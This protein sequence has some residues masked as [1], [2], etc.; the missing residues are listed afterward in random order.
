MRE[1]VNLWVLSFLCFFSIQLLEGQEKQDF[2]FTKGADNMSVITMGSLRSPHCT[3]F[4]YPD[5]LVLHEIPKI[6]KQVKEHDSLNIVIKENPLIAF[7]DSIYLNKPIKYILNSHSHSHSLSTILPF[8]DRGAMLITAIENIEIYEKRGLFG[9]LTIADYSKSIIEISADTVLLSNTNNPIEVLYL[10]KSDYKSIPTPTYLF[11]NFPKQKLLATSCM[12]YLKDIDDRFGYKA[13][14]YSDR[15]INVNKIIADKN[16]KVESTLQ[17]YKFRSEH[18][19]RK[20]PVF[21]ASHLE[22]VLKYSWHRVQLSEHFQ[23]MSYEDLRTKKD[24][25]LN[26][27]IESDIYHIIVNHAVYELIAKKEYQKAVALAQILIMYEPGSLNEIDTLGEAY[28]NNGQME[29]ANYYN[30]IIAESKEEKV[31]LGLMAWEKNK[32]DRLRSGS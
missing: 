30:N 29:M 32:E 25:L 13:I 16:L 5:F 9:D 15:L 20:P 14:V 21:P 4:E 26:Y 10:K 3:V 2:F 22:N 12:V 19:L 6:P 1:I 18:G 31:G 28:Y 23:N 17:L 24:S 27:L 11:F 7:I 8:I